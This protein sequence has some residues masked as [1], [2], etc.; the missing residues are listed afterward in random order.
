MLLALVGVLL[1]VIL[2]E[3]IQLRLARRENRELHENLRPDSC[4]FK[5]KARWYAERFPQV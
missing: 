5:R 2:I 3:E 4:L 1:G